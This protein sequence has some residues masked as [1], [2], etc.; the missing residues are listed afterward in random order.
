MTRLTCVVTIKSVQAMRI[1]S[2][3]K[4]RDDKASLHPMKIKRI[5]VRKRLDSGAF[6]D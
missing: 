6:F 1:F 2:G 4:G 5:I 3:S